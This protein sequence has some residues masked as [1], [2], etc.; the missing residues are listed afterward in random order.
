VQSAEALKRILHAEGIAPGSESE[1]ALLRF[2]AL[3]QKWGLH[4]NL[5]GSGEWRV[6][7]PLFQEALWSAKFYPGSAVRHLDIGSGAGF[8]AI[9]L[10]V[11]QPQ[12]KLDMVEARAKKVV[13]LETVAAELGIGTTRVHHARFEQFLSASDDVWDCFSWK[14]LKLNTRDVGQMVRH[15]HAQT[16]FWVFHGREVPVEDP[17]VLAEHMEILR[18]ERFPGRKDWALSIYIPRCVS[19]ETTA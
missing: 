1:G 12:I 14:A 11:L 2:L 6:I 9:P 15:A 3:L 4:V 17:A 16:Q 18:R 5:T 8:P 13:F 7:G 19:R 10:R